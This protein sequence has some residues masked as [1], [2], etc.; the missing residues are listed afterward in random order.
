MRDTVLTKAVIGH[1][2][3]LRKAGLVLGGS[4]LIAVAAQVSVPFYPVPLTLQTFAVLLAGAVLGG[5]WGAVAVLVYLALAA[6]GLPVLSDGTG[7]WQRF[8]GPTA[9]YLFAFPVAAFI[10]GTLARRPAFAGPASGVALMIGAHLLILGLGTAWLAT[11]VGAGPAM[12]AGF[13]PFL[14]GAGVKSA[15]VVVCAAALR[16]TVWF[17]RD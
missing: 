12:A 7:G 10:A 2:T 8:A 11:R 14:A 1:D 5:T 16:R 4:F 9:G 15:A 3:L 6:L 13:T 17:R